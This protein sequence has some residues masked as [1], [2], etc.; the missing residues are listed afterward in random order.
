MIRKKLVLI[1]IEIFWP[2]SLRVLIVQFLSMKLASVNTSPDYKVDALMSKEVSTVTSN[3]HN[4][5]IF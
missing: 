5:S 2:N 1:F 4:F 3:T